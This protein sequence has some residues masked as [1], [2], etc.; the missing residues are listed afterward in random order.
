MTAYAGQ[1]LTRTT[2]VQGGIRGYQ[3][4]LESLV[5]EAVECLLLSLFMIRQPC[6]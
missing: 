2:L 6:D 5:L 1:T 3:G 4:A